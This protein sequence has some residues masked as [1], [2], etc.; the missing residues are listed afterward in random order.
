MIDH[1]SLHDIRAFVAIA[2]HQSF[3][4]AAEQ[5]GSSRARLS[6]QLSQLEEQLG[7]QLLIRTTRSMRLTDAGGL[8]FEQCK[9]SL[10]NMAF[11]LSQLQESRTELSGQIRMNSLG[12]V[13][14]ERYL[15]RAISE[16]CLLHPKI[17]INLDF[18]SVKVDL[19]EEQFDLVLRAGFL[20]DSGLIARP[21]MKMDIATL[22]SPTYLKTHGTPT[23]PKDLTAHNCAVGSISTWRY[24]RYID[25]EK[26]REDIKVKGNFSCR[27]GKALVEAA[28]SGLGIIRMPYLSLD[29]ELSTGKLTTLFKD[30]DTVST[31]I[32]L[33]YTQSDYRPARI[34]ALIEF[35]S[36][37]FIKNVPQRFG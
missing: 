1:I 11:A 25:G 12:G 33:L 18:S 34:Q 27:N 37:W 17:T 7:I 3:T 20:E 15:T 10:D 4:Q 9:T 16:F 14:G 6:R 35:L 29:N 26:I 22:A 13:L 5:L 36:P 23:H 32:N 30:W 8:L 31:P 2:E 24:R 28:S 21:L 19:I